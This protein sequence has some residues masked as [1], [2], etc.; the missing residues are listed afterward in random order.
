MCCCGAT[1]CPIRQLNP[2]VSPVK[3]APAQL[4]AADAELRGEYLRQVL[5]VLY[6]QCST[7]P[8]AGGQRVADYLVIPDARRPKLLVPM[9]SRRVAVAAVRRFS[10]PQTRLARLKRYAVVL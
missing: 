4:T 8:G 1:T 7:E 2:V 10:E 3:T 6:P 9:G 5:A